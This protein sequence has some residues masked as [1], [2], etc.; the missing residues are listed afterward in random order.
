MHRENRESLISYIKEIKQI[1]E[2]NLQFNNITLDDVNTA[3]I[4]NSLN[5]KHPNMNFHPS[6]ID[7]TAS[8]I[9]DTSS[10]NPRQH[11]RYIIKTT[12]FG[13]VHFAAV[14]AFKDEKNNISL[15]IVDSSLGANISIPFD[16][17]GY[18]KPNLKTLYIYT[19]IQNSPGDCLLFSLHFLK[20]MYIYA[21]DFE[22]LH[23]RIFANDISFTFEKNHIFSPKVCERNPKLYPSSD[24]DCEKYRV[25]LF[26][27]AIN[28]LPIGFFKHAH[29][30]RPLEAYLDRHQDEQESRVNNYKKKDGT[31]GE[32]LLERYNRH[33]TLRNEMNTRTNKPIERKYSISIEEKRLRLAEAALKWLDE[34]GE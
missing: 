32:T 19:Q 12:A 2:K 11:K 9:E 14:N 29:S 7:K 17:H 24:D 22:R 5:R 15:I 23:K 16:L 1:K 33:S 31:I 3:Y 26:N 34:H 28:L 4:L 6:I 30:L 8:L 13:G 10:L 27:Q 20:K 25:V 21:R 18:N